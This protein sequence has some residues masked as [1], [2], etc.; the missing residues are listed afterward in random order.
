[1]KAKHSLTEIDRLQGRHR[2][3]ISREIESGHGQRGYRAEQ[4]CNKSQ[5]RAQGSRNTRR[6][7][8]WVLAEVPFYLGLDNSKYSTSFRLKLIS[9]NLIY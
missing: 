9:N 7:Q 5:E 8:T 3:N 1:M 6:V 2:S 4:A